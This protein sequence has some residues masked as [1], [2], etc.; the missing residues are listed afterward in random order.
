MCFRDARHS[1]FFTDNG[2]PR[3][4]ERMMQQ[5]PQSMA[6]RA[7]LST[8]SIVVATILTVAA[9]IALAAAVGRHEESGYQIQDPVSRLE[10]HSIGMSGDT[11][12]LPLAQN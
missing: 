1:D 4:F 3:T 11:L 8:V 12:Q 9:L 7:R 6:R 5:L 10:L 2:T